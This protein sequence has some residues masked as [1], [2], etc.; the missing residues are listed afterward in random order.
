LE[1]ADR[2]M[3]YGDA[4][5]LPDFSPDHGVTPQRAA[6]YA[7]S[8]RYRQKSASPEGHAVEFKKLLEILEIGAV[9]ALRR[10][11]MCAGASLI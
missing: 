5:R 8:H 6:F 4:A 7:H 9:D 1:V 2:R 10:H 3:D 11:R